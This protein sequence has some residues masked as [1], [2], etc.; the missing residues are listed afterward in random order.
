MKT[1]EQY[2]TDTLALLPVKFRERLLLHLPLVDVCRLEES[3]QFTDGLDMEAIWEQLLSDYTSQCYSLNPEKDEL[4]SRTKFFKGLSLLV[5]HCNR[6]Y[7]YATT[8]KSIT[9][10][11]PTDDSD[12]ECYLDVVNYLAAI[13]L[14]DND[15]PE[16]KET[17]GAFKIREVMH[18][19]ISCPFFSRPYYVTQCSCKV[20]KHYKTYHEACQ[21]RQLIPSRHASLFPKGS[22]CLLDTTALRLI[23][24]KCCFH[25]QKVLIRIEEIKKLFLNAEQEDH[26]VVSVISEF[27]KDL[28]DVTIGGEQEE[29]QTLIPNREDFSFKLLKLLFDCRSP[30]ITSLKI[31]PVNVHLLDSL[32]AVL[33]SYNGLKKLTID[34]NHR[35]PLLDLRKMV[36]V[37]ERQLSLGS[38]SMSS[39]GMAE[40]SLEFSKFCLWIRVCL[41][42]P[43]F[44][45]CDLGLTG[46]TVPSEVLE[47]LIFFFTTQCSK[48]QLFVFKAQSVQKVIPTSKKTNKVLPSVEGA[49]VPWLKSVMF[50]QFRSVS[51]LMDCLMALGSLKLKGLALDRCS[52][53]FFSQVVL[54][55]HFEV[56]KLY[57]YNSLESA[58]FSQYDSLLGKASLKSVLIQFY[59]EKTSSVTSG[60]LEAAELHGFA[61]EETPIYKVILQYTLTRKCPKLS[62]H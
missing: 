61:V 33:A 37:T 35:V 46:T 7:K 10:P 40:H 30:K 11:V 22:C 29:K 38:I 27:F 32:Y 28:E 6:P 36:H 34:W 43:S 59:T 41:K 17:I 1:L 4:N 19:Y 60:L 18:H 8:D 14:P 25:C 42:C 31:H 48:E 47:L 20:V 16:G 55:P 21:A 62:S 13:K 12:E 57:V 54:H 5:L 39:V 24:T 53:S 49:C 15:N 45:T 50:C 9:S 23:R 51:V 3:A 2:T 52:T 26:S 56:E 44:H 58:S